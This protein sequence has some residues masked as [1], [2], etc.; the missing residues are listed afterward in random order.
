MVYD[1]S[2]GYW[3]LLEFRPGGGG[4]T[5]KKEKEHLY[6]KEKGDVSK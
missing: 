4:G 1:G 2:I 5:Y 6:R 3:I